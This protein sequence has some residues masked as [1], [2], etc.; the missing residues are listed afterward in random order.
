MEGGRL[1]WQWVK[2]GGPTGCSHLSRIDDLRKGGQGIPYTSGTG[3]QLQVLI[4]IHIPSPKP[5]LDVILL[6][7][8]LS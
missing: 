5:T 3:A 4:Y 7:V 6:H 8:V 2:T 1:I